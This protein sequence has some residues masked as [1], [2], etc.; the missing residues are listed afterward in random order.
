MA[1]K[2]LTFLS[3][4]SLLEIFKAAVLVGFLV[5]FVGTTL[6]AGLLS[7]SSSFS[8]FFF[9]SGVVILTISLVLRPFF[10]TAVA[11]FG[12]TFTDFVMGLIG[13]RPFW[14]AH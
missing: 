13:G 1:V 7:T 4:G 8:V 3:I 6:G 14:R 10:P 2:G 12:V 11:F 5:G 9:S